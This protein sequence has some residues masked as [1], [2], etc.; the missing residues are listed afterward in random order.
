M[1]RQR[2]QRAIVI[3]AGMAVLAANPVHVRAD[4][5][6]AS[7][8]NVI[9]IVTDDQRF[10]T[11]WAMPHVR[12]E[13][14]AQGVK[15]TD[16][17][18]VNPTCCPSRS[19]ILTG[20]YSHSTGVYSNKGDHGGFAAFDPSSTVATWLHDAGYETAL[21]GKYLNGYTGT[22][23]PPG[24]D[25]FNAF[26]QDPETSF[27][28]NYTM[29]VNG[30]T[31]AFGSAESDYSTTVLGDMAAEFIE[32][33]AD[34]FFLY[35]APRAPHEP[36]RPAPRDRSAFTGLDP[37]RPPSYNEADVSDKPPWLRD[38]PLLAKTKQKAIDRFRLRQYRTL[39]AVDRLVGNL[40]AQLAQAD[41]LANTAI[42]FTSDNG[43]LWGEHRLKGKG[44][45]Y[46]ESIHVPLVIRFDAVSG[47]APV[48]HELVLN[49]DLAPT[50]AAI[51]GIT[52][53]TEPDGSSLI[54]LLDGSVG[55]LRNH[56]L[57]EHLGPS[58]PTF[59]AVRGVRFLYVAYAT[60]DEELYDLVRDPWQLD[61]S[62]DRYPAKR[63][64]LLG[65][66]QQLCQPPP[67]DYTVPTA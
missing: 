30:T 45:P 51:A 57:I 12:Q 1:K 38:D 23:I 62:V 13:L 47:G 64:K 3:A 36:A 39:L 61:N 65:W 17:F 31:Q 67:P 19:S 53:A 25:V 50:I 26:N 16:A 42:I 56:F 20:L 8:P 7:S 6:A 55:S 2:V 32:S 29:N 41:R 33:S 28:Y 4:K 66:L 54:P 22:V 58:P 63:A 37:W 40:M 11:L 35:L 21:V 5:P 52:P 34:P 18:V 9:L 14:V 27:Y 59:C 49:I 15:F 43:M 46:E 24:W 60:G 44:V 10:D 48:D